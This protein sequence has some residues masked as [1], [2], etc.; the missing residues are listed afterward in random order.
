M[1][2]VFNFSLTRKKSLE[3]F[4]LNHR[5]HRPGSSLLLLA[6]LPRSNVLSRVIPHSPIGAFTLYTVDS[7]FLPVLPHTLPIFI[8]LHL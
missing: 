6:Y 7:D 2:T 8:S 1:S 3:I 5:L 4:F